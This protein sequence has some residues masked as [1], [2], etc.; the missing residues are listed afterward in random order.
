MARL[1][2]LE[3]MLLTAEDY[4]NK[5]NMVR[6]RVL[7]GIHSREAQEAQGEVG[8]KKIFERFAASNLHNVKLLSKDRVQEALKEVSSEMTAEDLDDLFERDIDDPKTGLTFEEFKFMITRQKPIEQWAATVPFARL[9]ADAVKVDPNFNQL[10]YVANL[11]RDDI[12]AIVIGM[13]EGLI[14]VIEKHVKLL[15]EGLQAKKTADKPAGSKFQIIPMN[16]G[17]LNDFHNGLE[18]RVGEEALQFHILFVLARHTYHTHTLHVCLA[19]SARL[20]PPS[21]TSTCV[22][23]LAR[24]RVC[25]RL[26]A[27][28]QAPPASAS[29]KP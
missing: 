14:I 17:R 20:R 27:R 25:A 5:Q 3:E 23:A 26:F 28:A 8:W 29:S 2:N 22:S 11:S 16:C 4:I 6:A 19:A 15:S 7:A 10:K 18:G 21:S 9:F 12:G 13:V 1:R 24:A